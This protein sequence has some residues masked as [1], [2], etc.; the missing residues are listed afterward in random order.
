MKAAKA[1]L[2][3][4]QHGVFST[5]YATDDKFE[6]DNRIETIRKHMVE[7]EVEDLTLTEQLIENYDFE[8]NHDCQLNAIGNIGRGIPCGWE[9]LGELKKGANGLDSYGVNQGASNYH[10]NNV[11]WMNSVPMPDEFWLYQTIPASKLVPGTYRVRCKLWVENGKKTC[12]RLFANKNV[13]YYGTENDYTNL[14]TEGEVNTYAGYAGGNTDEFVLKDME[15]SVDIK[16]GEDLMI[17]IK[18]GNMRN[19]GERSTN[20]NS[21]WFKVDYFRIHRIAT[22]EVN[23]SVAPLS[24]GTTRLYTLTGIPVTSAKKG[25]YVQHKN[26]QNGKII[27]VTK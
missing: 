24:N 3:A 8:Y 26:G 7:E 18:S 20:D 6:M 4:S 22:T 1:A 17:G 16:E 2:I 27:I 25:L 10:G 12:C 11:C 13:Q 15:V 9:S 14:L 23:N 5:W 19:N 21:G